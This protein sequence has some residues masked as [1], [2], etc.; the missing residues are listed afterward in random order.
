[1]LVWL[2][3][4]VIFAGFRLAAMLS[5]PVGGIELDSLAGAWQAQAGNADE[6]F[7]PTLFQAVTSWTFVFTS[8]EAPA[9]V[10]ALMASCSVPFALYRLRPL[11]GET[12]A[13]AALLLL[14]IDP[15]SILF[16]GTAW[17]GGFDLATTAWLVVFLR[18]GRLPNWAVGLAAF[19]VASGGALA[20]PIV[21]GFAAV[22]LIRQE[23]PTRER[24]LW[25]AGGV[26]AAGFLAATGFGHG[27]QDPTLPPIT[28]FARGF[29]AT[30]S[31]VNTNSL[32][33][34]YSLPLLMLGIVAASYHAYECWRDE[35]WPE[36]SLALLAA[37]ALAFLWVAASGGSADPVP[38]GAAAIPF[39]LLVGK[40]APAAIAAILRVPWLY[41]GP[42]LAGLVVTALV[43]EAYTVDWAR[44]DR[45]GSDRTKLIVT[46]L[47]IASVACVGLLSSSR[48][49][50]P[51]LLLPAVGTAA[52]LMLS[53][54]TG[55]A[56]GGPNEPLPSPVSTIQGSEI[57]E[58]ALR[59]REE[60]GG[61]I[62]VHSGFTL[63]SAWPLRD[64]GE[65]VYATRVPP[66][67]TVVVWPVTEPAPDGFSVIE[68]RWSFEETRR[69]PD[70]G[71]LDYLR[72]LSNRNILKNGFEPVAV[73][74]KATP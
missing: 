3:L 20:L 21:L 52:V 22:R 12:G 32:A 61:L 33:M 9:R 16:G 30:W 42:A 46:G 47:V 44:I 8:S 72:W 63:T 62:V 74:L 36:E 45:V 67:A 57:R 50:A 56:F 65:L 48:R 23:Y 40:V 58:I 55:V 19:V 37:A 53:G 25:A 24:A 70:G 28:A 34:L 39:A 10:L 29:E 18:E 71:F 41:A 17:H 1:M 43:A 64:S 31:T 7:I 5:A 14:A 4:G 68:G 13:M 59:A 69:G 27:F 15:V 6:R 66:D 26:A 51:A 38:L 2:G 60:N 35:H 54:S 73:Y 11:L 49:T